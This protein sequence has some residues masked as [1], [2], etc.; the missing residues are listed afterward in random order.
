MPSTFLSPEPWQRLIAESRRFKALADYLGFPFEKDG[1]GVYFP[2]SNRVV[3]K[4]EELFAWGKEKSNGEELF[5]ILSAIKDK[6]DKTGLNLQG[7][8]LL[9]RILLDIEFEKSTKAEDKETTEK[10]ADE[11][12]KNETKLKI[13]KMQEELKTYEQLAT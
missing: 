11:K 13:K 4:L 8:S 1:K 12:A 3:E 7:E 2:Y 9:R 6:V 5:D 10:K